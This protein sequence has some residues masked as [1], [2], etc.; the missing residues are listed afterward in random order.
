MSVSLII[1]GMFT[2]PAVLVDIETN[3]G[4]GERGRIIEV[5]AIKVIDGEIV[6]EFRSL[7]NPGGSIPRWIT[8]LTG[9]TT[10]DIVTAPYFNDIAYQLFTFMEDCL[11][12][13]HNVRFDY[14]FLKR[15]FKIAGYDFRPPLFCTVR[16]SRALY[17]EVRGHSLEKIIQRH[18]LHVD[19][20][21]RAYDDAR[22]LHAFMK[23]ALNERGQDAF[24]ANLVLQL[25]TRSLPPNVDEAVI[26][27]LPDTPG[28]YIFE[29]D[30]GA[31]LYVGKSINIR[32]RVRSHF[33][34]ATE[35]A[36]EMRLSLQ[37]HNISF[38]QTETELEALLLESAKI[39]ELSP[40][41]N[42]LLRRK[43][44]QSILVKD[45]AADGYLT[46]SIQNADLSQYQNL[47]N[48][49][50]VYRTKRQAQAEL[51]S[52]ARTYQL[53]PKLLWLEKTT[54]ACFRFQLGLCR[55][56]CIGKESPA[57][58]NTRLEFAL[59]RT[60]IDSW[61]FDSEVAVKLSETRMMIIDQWIVKAIV[62]D[63]DEQQGVP[64]EGGFDLDAYKIIR[65][66]IRRNPQAIIRLS[67]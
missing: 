20:R 50:G 23:L 65:A 14:S 24:N 47:E 58:Y 45:T 42:R 36:R 60:K 53:C 67:D 35:I 28:I 34:S 31:P 29:D 17:P 59:E 40:S 37:S 30:T 4:S 26:L 18:N 15:E 39:K 41:Y 33:V 64:V 52:A 25:K 6:D 11:F 1:G 44:T 38:I 10:D 48:V 22:V 56:A 61:P 51:E 62:E 12:V 13:A 21:H 5:A 55:G 8:T 9:I 63:G 3:G 32:Q 49:Y 16:L 57:S 66:Y 19:A 7:V 46:I 43:T 2:T 54:G 27:S